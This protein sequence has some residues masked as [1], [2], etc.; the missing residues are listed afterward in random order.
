MNESIRIVFRS[1]T[2]T[3][4]LTDQLKKEGIVYRMAR[5]VDVQRG[6]TNAVIIA[7]AD[8]ARAQAIMRQIGIRGVEIR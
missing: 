3:F 2:D 6:C 8:L 4:A 5:P 7:R 1:Q